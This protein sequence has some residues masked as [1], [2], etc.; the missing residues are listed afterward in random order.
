MTLSPHDRN[1]VARSKRAKMGYLDY[2]G[3]IQ[4]YPESGPLFL[5]F[6][7]KQ[8]DSHFFLCHGYIQTN[9]EHNLFMEYARVRVDGKRVHMF[10][11]KQ[12]RNGKGEIV[13]SGGKDLTTRWSGTPCYVS[14]ERIGAGEHMMEIL[15]VVGANGTSSSIPLSHLIWF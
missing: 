5:R 1:A 14:E 7:S 4:G 10:S 3:V 11:E 6:T 9:H 8:A 2:K 13:F 12:A 15:P